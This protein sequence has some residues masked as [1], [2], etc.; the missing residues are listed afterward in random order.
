MDGRTDRQMVLR[1]FAKVHFRRTKNRGFAE[2]AKQKF[3]ELAA[4]WQPRRPL[5]NLS[6]LVKN[7]GDLDL[8]DLSLSILGGLDLGG[9]SNP[10]LSGLGGLRDP[11]LSGK[12]S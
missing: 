11:G 2:Y 9:L 3:T 5:G 10:G 1:D 12:I 8:G 6:N 4:S 7:L